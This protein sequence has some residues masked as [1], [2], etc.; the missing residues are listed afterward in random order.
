MAFFF[1]RKV[2]IIFAWMV[3][4]M[5]F[6]IS[7][8]VFKIIQ[9]HSYAFKYIPFF[10]RSYELWYCLVSQRLFDP[11]T[12][13]HRRM[14]F[15]VDSNCQVDPDY[16]RARHGKRQKNEHDEA[17]KNRKKVKYFT[18]IGN[19]R[20]AARSAARTEWRGSFLDY[21]ESQGPPVKSGQTKGE[22]K[23]REI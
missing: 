21:S 4:S 8:K 7:R 5:L 16:Q 2:S 6:T 10:I 3:Y 12:V 11:P 23:C 19:W 18:W 13:V 15:V 20:T 9:K 1:N 14:K 17:K 22:G